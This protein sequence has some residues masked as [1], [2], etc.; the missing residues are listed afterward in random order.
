VVF[1]PFVVSRGEEPE[2]A[3]LEIFT[4]A[5]Q[6]IHLQRRE[7]TPGAPLQPFSW[8]GILENGE[9]AASG[10]YGYV[11]RVGRERRSGR[12]ILLK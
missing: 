11:I 6:R 5:G 1:L 10:V 3:I 7:L 8:N 2:P 4:I 12:F 9:P